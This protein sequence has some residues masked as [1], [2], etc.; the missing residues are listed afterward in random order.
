MTVDDLLDDLFPPNRNGFRLDELARH[1]R[2]STQHF[3]NLVRAG[4]L[5][6]PPDR[7]ESAPSHTSIIVPRESICAFVRKR[8]S[9][10]FLKSR[11]KYQKKGG[12]SGNVRGK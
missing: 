9:K 12:E 7:I 11:K 4:E 2:C 1:F 10:A 5:S 6:V 8:S 3:Y